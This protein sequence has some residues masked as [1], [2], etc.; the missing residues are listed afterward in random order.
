M[1]LYIL[2]PTPLEGGDGGGLNQPFEL[3]FFLWIYIY[4]WKK[5]RID[6]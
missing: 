6:R 2:I 5:V 1:G 4:I 3:Q